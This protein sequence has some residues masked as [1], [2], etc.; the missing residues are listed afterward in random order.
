MSPHISTVRERVRLGGEPITETQWIDGFNAIAGILEEMTHRGRRLTYFEV[1]WMLA[2]ERFRHHK[3]NAFLVE[4]GMGGR[5]DC[6]NLIQPEVAVMMPISHD[7]TRILGRR[8]A[9]IAWDKSHILKPGV[10]AVIA[11]QNRWAKPEL[12]LRTQDNGITPLWFGQDYILNETNDGEEAGVPFDVSVDGKWYRDLHLKLMGRHQRHNAA[13]AI[14]AMHVFMQSINRTLD[15]DITRRIL[16]R[17][18]IPG[19]LEWG[20]HNPDVLLDVAHNPASFRALTQTLRQ[21]KNSRRIHAIVGFARGKDSRKCL[22]ILAPYVNQI[23]IVPTGTPRSQEPQKLLKI[24]HHIGMRAVTA[25]GGVE[26]LTQLMEHAGRD[27]IL[28][29]GSFPLVGNCRNYLSERASH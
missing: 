17:V 13:V 2:L 9:Q 4:V 23:H 26:V 19:R 29:A 3:P 11:R 28:V 12:I 24:A 16:A 15:P 1:T 25:T 14:A 6:T 7:H 22:R 27:L 21:W 20:W 10:Q 5:L 8:I 18:S